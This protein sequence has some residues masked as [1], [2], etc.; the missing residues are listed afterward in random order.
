MGQ[1]CVLFIVGLTTKTNQVEDLLE[2]D[3][4]RRV[5]G[6]NT[7]TTVTNGLVGDARRRVKRRNQ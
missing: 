6:T 3:E 7:G 1:T 2:G 5:G 4:S